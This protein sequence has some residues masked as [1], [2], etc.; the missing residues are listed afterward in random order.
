[1]V[2]KAANTKL[3]NFRDQYE[4]TVS[5]IDADTYETVIEVKNAD[6]LDEG[7]R[8]KELGCNPAVLNMASAKR[9]GGGYNNGAGAQ[10]EN[11]F[12]RTNLFQVLEDLDHLHPNRKWHYPLPEFSSVY[13]PSVFVIR[14][15]EQTGTLSIRVLNVVHSPT[16]NYAGYAFLKEPVELAFIAVAAYAHPQTIKTRSGALMLADKFIDKTMRKMRGLLWTALVNNHD[17]IVLSALGCGA[18]KNPP[19]HIAR[20]FKKV[21]EEPSFRGK[22]KHIVFAIF[23]T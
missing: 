17:S 3:N 20:L 9:A 2:L 11:L 1:M 19:L 10:E 21:L 5:N 23:G 14:S 6:C 4:F 7:I 12:R 13:S 8:L 15:S 22:F 18:Y 16:T